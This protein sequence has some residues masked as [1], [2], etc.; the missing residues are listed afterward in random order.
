[1]MIRIAFCCGIL[2]IAS[3][4]VEAKEKVDFSSDIQ[5]LLA[6]NC[7]ACHG[8]DAGSRKADL[9]L[10]QRS[11]AVE[12]GVIVPG[13]PDESE[14]I[15]RVETN[16]SILVMPPVDSGHS[17]TEQEIA[18]F[19][20]WVAE[21]AEYEE[22]WSFSPPVKVEPPQVKQA[23][24]PASAIDH[25]VLRRLEEAGLQPQ[26]EADRLT[27]IRRVSLDLTG[28]PPTVE[29][30]EAFVTDESPDAYEKVVDR[31]LASPAYGER[32]ARMWLDLARYADTKGY[33]KDRHRDIWR[34][35]DWVINAFNEDMPYD[36]FTIEQLAGDL[37]PDRTT[38][39]LLATAFHRNTM[40]NEEG[41]TDNE[42]F[43]VAAVK[44][45]VDTT[46]QVWMGLTMGC[47]KCHSHKYDP[48]TINDYYSFYAFFNQT[49][50]ADA[51]AP[52]YPTP[53][54]EQARQ[55][56]LQQVKLQELKSEPETDEAAIKEAEEALKAIQESIPKTPVMLEL[57]P[58]KQ[59][60]TKLHNRGNFLDQGDE[61][62]PAVLTEFVDAPEEVEPNRLA[63]A[64]WLMQADNPLTSRVMVNRLWARLFGVGLVETEED[65]GTQ[66]T[67]PSHPELL[68]WLAVD[69]RENGWSMKQLLKTIVMSRTYRQDSETTLELIEADPR[70]RLLSRGPHFRLPAEVVRDQALAVSGLLTEKIGGP[71]V[72]PPQ[73]D[74]I[75]K[76]TYSG[77]S[78]QNAEGPDR[79][80]RALYTYL[81]RTSPYPAMITFDAGSGEV[82]QVRRV[83]TNTPLQALVTLN[84]TAFVEAAGALA[85]R[86]DEAGDTTRARIAHGFRRVLIRPATAAELDRLVE[87]Y[88]SLDGDLLD[89]EE[90]LKAADIEQG[91]ARLVAVANVLL[92]LDETVMKP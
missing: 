56:E 38:E 48:I 92:N 50:D 60:L 24:W 57:A 2:L 30:A 12:A 74:G 77:E 52:F 70:N 53:T 61:V 17:L 54:A 46:L 83:R 7:L 23:D 11:T 91:D 4:G 29:E 41:G 72:M 20:Q 59:R 42:E 21:G 44:D 65:F 68:D 63:V 43:R 45:R 90:L 22:H 80:R 79:Y 89:A 47:A 5:P 3:T 75:W 33:E 31:L 32:W 19:R 49:Q 87:L 18:L 39:Q 34:Y 76:S 15:A 67:P 85:K 13:E 55:L 69:F 73:P 86:M 40:T 27:L 51:E 10:D 9:R 1:M 37:L 25:F 66:G 78:W 64:K 81:K 28:L 71:S 84:D 88:D 62:Q 82:C 36:Q 8:M 16:D 6:K 35:R 58:K 14:L 26:F